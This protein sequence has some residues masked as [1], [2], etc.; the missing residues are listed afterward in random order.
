[1]SFN[2]SMETR[3]D[4]ALIATR[5]TSPC[6]LFRCTFALTV[7][8]A[9]ALIAGNPSPGLGSCRV[10]SE[11]TQVHNRIRCV[12]ITLVC[13]WMENN[14]KCDYRWE[15]VFMPDLWQGLR[16]QVQPEGPHPDSFQ[17]ET[18]YVP[19]LWKSFRSEVISL[20]ARRIVVHEDGH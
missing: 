2:N 1:M 3:L 4:A 20:Q 9:S 15:A 16:R 8:D 6:R 10:T 11:L 13:R 12:Y 7:K 19:T 17:L 14:L 5:F 18:V